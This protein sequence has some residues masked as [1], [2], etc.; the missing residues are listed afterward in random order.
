M[1]M[2]CSSD[3][4]Q[5]AV[6]AEVSSTSKR[7]RKRFLYAVG[8][9]FDETIDRLL[10]GLRAGVLGTVASDDAHKALSKQLTAALV[11]GEPVV[12]QDRSALASYALN[13]LKPRCKCLSNV[14]LAE[15]C[16]DVLRNIIDRGAC[17]R[18]LRISSIG[19]GPGF[20]AVSLLA[21]L[22]AV[23]ASP[24]AVHVECDVLDLYP[25]WEE[26]VNALAEEVEKIWS[27]RQLANN[28]RMISPVDLRCGEGSESEKAVAESVAKADIIV[29]AYVL[30]ENEA[31]LLSAGPEGTL[32]GAIPTIFRS[33]SQNAVFL[34]LDATHRLWP[35]LIATSKSLSSTEGIGPFEVI[36][37]SRCTSHL[38]A[39]LFLRRAAEADVAA[40][41][42][43][44]MMKNNILESYSDHQLAYEARRERLQRCS[45]ENDSSDALGKPCSGAS[46]NTIT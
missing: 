14:L 4:T 20:D 46:N 32:S 26:A 23:G 15:E 1:R 7:A 25:A 19:G 2:T 33:M 35:A 8:T 12:F 31:A 9:K 5:M 41:Q 44:D 27:P 11:D 38:H 30:H 17:P 6:A 18:P 45:P 42:P 40:L 24:D 37:P 22:D 16:S 39:I 36:L 28:I 29:A 43:A 10:A 34:C 21:T 13:R 3:E